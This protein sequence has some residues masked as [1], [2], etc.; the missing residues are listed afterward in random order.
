MDLMDPEI[1]VRSTFL[2]DTLK[3]MARCMYVTRERKE[4]FLKLF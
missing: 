3:F 1:T 2:V 4:K